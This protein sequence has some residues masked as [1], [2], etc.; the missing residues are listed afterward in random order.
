MWL[1]MAVLSAFFAGVTAILAKCGIRH[2]DSDVATA[3]RTVVVLLFAWVMVWI[4]GSA[5]TIG[6]ISTTS[7]VFLILSGLA[8]GGSWLCYFKALSMADVNKVAPVDKSSTIL[9]VLLAVVLFSETSH[10][11][12]KLVG[13]ALLAVG[14]YLM[15]EKKSGQSPEKQDRRWIVYAVLSAVFGALTSILAKVGITGVESN[16]GT[17]IRTGVVLVVSWGIVAARGKLRQI[18][19]VR[20]RE[21]AWIL[22]SG[23]TTGA[24]WLCYYY[25]IGNGV[26]SVV[27]PIDK[28]SILVTVLLSRVILKERI[29]GKAG[30]GL[31]LMLA[32]TVTIALCG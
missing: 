8:T 27:V 7:V 16:L 10:L 15:I 13:T 31:A 1:I 32:G 28:M 22:L 17:A 3:L 19:K 12:A 26:V 24:S 29:G 18:P 5:D 6:Q 14:I 30:L 11:G 25:A 23:V 21:L 20:G 4:V 2:T 9:S